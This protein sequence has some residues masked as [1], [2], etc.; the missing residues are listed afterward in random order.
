M[1]LIFDQFKSRAAAERFS[2]AVTARFGLKADVWDSREAMHAA[3]AE[4]SASGW[5]GT[6][7]PEGR[8]IDVFPFELDGPIALVER[9]YDETEA[10][11]EGM[12][13]AHGCTFAGT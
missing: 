13:V 12:A 7:G 5:P 8:L 4:A 1:C 6:P 11:V 3:A 9:T 2:A 10:A